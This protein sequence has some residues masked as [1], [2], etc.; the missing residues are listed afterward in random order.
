MGADTWGLSATALGGPLEPHW[1][2]TESSPCLVSSGPSAERWYTPGPVPLQ[3]SKPEPLVAVA[4]PRHLAA[5]SCSAAGGDALTGRR[6]RGR[7]GHQKESLYFV[8]RN[9]L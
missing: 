4:A 9:T 8:R 3:L 2:R 7:R 6:W 1:V 5:G